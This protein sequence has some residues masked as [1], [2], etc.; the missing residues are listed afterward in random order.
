MPFFDCLSEVHGNPLMDFFSDFIDIIYPARCKSCDVFLDENALKGLDFCIDCLEDFSEIRPPFC[1]KC[2]TPFEPESGENH[3]CEKCLRKPPYYEA[4]GSPYLYTGKIMDVIHMFKYLGKSHYARTLG[5]LMASFSLK[6][7]EK[8]KNLLIMPVPLH[9]KKL[10]KRGFN[11][12]LLLAREVNRFLKVNVDFLSLRR[13]KITPS[14]AELKM[15]ERIKNVRNAFEISEKS[16]IK[17]RDILLV[18]DVA[19]TGST[20]NECSRILL[21]AGARRVICL[22]LARTAI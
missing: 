17:G 11:Q 19:T 12:S 15:N 18:D 1:L 20:L 22:V 5:I 4:L 2:R 3:L 14:Q 9:P 16:N 10:R 7:L 6:W 13:I 21:K 8:E